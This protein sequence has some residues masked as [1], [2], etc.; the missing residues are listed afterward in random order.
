MPTRARTGLLLGGLLV[1]G[2][3]TAL[4]FLAGYALPQRHFLLIG[5]ASL[6]GWSPYALVPVLLVAAALRSWL[7]SALLAVLLAAQVAVLLPSYRPDSVRS[8][9][10]IVVMTSNL[11]LG[12]ADADTVVGLV[13]DR[14]V[15]LLALVELTPPEVERLRAAGLDQLLPHSV[16][17][18]ADGAAGT[19]LWSRQPLVEVP[20]WRATFATAAA[21]VAGVRFRALHPFPPLRGRVSTWSADYAAITADA[22]RETTAPTVLLGDL[23]ASVHHRALRTLM[24][25]RWRD[26]AALAGAG[27]VRTWGPFIGRPPVL[28]P[29]HVLVDRG[30]SVAAYDTAQVDG[31]DHRAV[32]VTLVLPTRP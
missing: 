10:R 26:A 18:A 24:G 11:A 19:G 2:V 17:M 29:D 13:R 15:D 5:A 9:P 8:G 3:L 23:N 16:V 6:A 32:V 31:S 22:R 14:H 21:D 7:A 1:A 25:E 30:M 27:L 28:D 20:P 4:P 12:Q